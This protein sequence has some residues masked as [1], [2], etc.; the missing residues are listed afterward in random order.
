VSAAPCDRLH[1]LQARRVVELDENRRMP[2]SV[3][4]SATSCG[5]VTVSGCVTRPIG[6][7][8]FPA[9]DTRRMSV[10]PGE[11]NPPRADKL[12]VNDPQRLRRGIQRPHREVAVAPSAAICTWAALSQLLETVSARRAIGPGK[13]DALLALDINR[14][15]NRIRSHSAPVSQPPA[16]ERD[17]LSGAQ[18]CLVLD[19]ATHADLIGRLRGL[20]ILLGGRLTLVQ[21]RSVDELIDAAEFG[22]ALEMLADCLSANETPI[23]DGVRRDFDR[24]SLQMGNV[25]RVMRP[26][27]R[28]PAENDS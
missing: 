18:D 28:C 21:A 17:H 12:R 6:A 19:F 23:P 26:L 10:V 4:G 27:D 1:T 3:T 13:D 11:P 24:L 15:W 5:E 20:I 14:H 7:K 9:V 2:K 16:G 8:Q 22:A 25:E